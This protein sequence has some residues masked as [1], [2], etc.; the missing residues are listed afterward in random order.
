MCQ[1][2]NNPH[3][4]PPPPTPSRAPSAPKPK[5]NLN[6]SRPPQLGAVDATQAQSLAQKYGVQG[7]PTIKAFPAGKKKGPQDYNGPREAPGI[8]DYATEVSAAFSRLLT[9]RVKPRGSDRVE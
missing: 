1:L 7:Y 2:L 9:G 8:V 4:S 6:A 3:L 5:P